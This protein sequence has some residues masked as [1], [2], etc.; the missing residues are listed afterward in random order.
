MYVVV[1]LG[2]ASPTAQAYVLHPLLQ[3]LVGK[4]AERHAHLAAVEV[5][6]NYVRALV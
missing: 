5:L 2:N 4:T 1:E 3:L 6:G